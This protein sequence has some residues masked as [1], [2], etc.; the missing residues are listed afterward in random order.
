MEV[1][2]TPYGEHFIRN[3]GSDVD[4]MEDQTLGELAAAE[5]FC[6]QNANLDLATGEIVQATNAVR[7]VMAQGA[8]PPNKILYGTLSRPHPDDICHVQTTDIAYDPSLS[9]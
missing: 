4:K 9:A 2:V 3:S 1:R 6:G 7:A 8:Q 5:I